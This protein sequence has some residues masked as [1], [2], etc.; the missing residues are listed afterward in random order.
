MIATM[1]Y[2]IGEEVAVPVSPDTVARLSKSTVQEALQALLS[3][4]TGDDDGTASM[5]R[6]AV[7]DPRSVVEVKSA[8]GYAPLEHRAAAKAIL[9]GRQS[10]EIMV[11]RP[12]AGG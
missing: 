1:K 2:G 7:S 12:H 8:D 6:D 5:L 9:Q 3:G 11:S 10:L 4:I